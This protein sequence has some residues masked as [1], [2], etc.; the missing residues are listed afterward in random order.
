MAY[1]YVTGMLLGANES[2]FQAKYSQMKIPDFPGL[3]PGKTAVK[4]R[5]VKE[6]VDL[7]HRD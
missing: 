2:S 1:I 6:K 7:Q 4:R 5:R 3:F